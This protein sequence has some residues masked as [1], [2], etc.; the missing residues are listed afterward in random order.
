MILPSDKFYIVVD[1]DTGDVRR[2]QGTYNLERNWQVWELVSGD[3]PDV[4]LYSS[5]LLAKAQMIRDICGCP[6]T[7]TSGHRTITFNAL[8]EVG[9]WEKSYHLTGDALDLVPPSSVGMGSFYNICLDVCGFNSGIGQ[10]I[11][12]NFVHIDNGSHKRWRK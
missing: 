10:Y 5:G 6:V 4:V 12:K 3:N 1:V 2:L 11:K 7:C 8:P 9:G